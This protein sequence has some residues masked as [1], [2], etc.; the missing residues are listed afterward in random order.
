VH[1]C[2]ILEMNAESYRMEEAKK[3]KKTA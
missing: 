2:V 1:H 3:N